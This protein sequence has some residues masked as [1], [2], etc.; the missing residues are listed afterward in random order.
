ML[1]KEIKEV[2]GQSLFFVGLSLLLPLLLKLILWS[3]KISF[4]ELY[5]IPLQIGLLYLAMFLGNSLFLSD[6]RQKAVDYLLSLPYSKLRLLGIK[7]LPR[8]GALLCFYILFILAYRLVGR[9][10]FF[11]ERRGL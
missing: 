5:L 1:R 9:G 6:R 10:S 11:H 4:L 8:I 3:E 2:L 7:T